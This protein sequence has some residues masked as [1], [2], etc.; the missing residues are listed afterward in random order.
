[1]TQWLFDIHE[2]IKVGIRLNL[3]KEIHLQMITVFKYK[4]ERCTVSPKQVNLSPE[5]YNKIKVIHSVYHL[6]LQSDFEI[7]YL[8]FNKRKRNCGYQ[9]ETLQS[10]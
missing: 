2:F 4:Q 1:M 3:Y 9:S 7:V 5:I 10:E 8:Q 6:S